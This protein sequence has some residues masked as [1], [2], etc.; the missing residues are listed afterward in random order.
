MNASVDSSAS[1]LIQHWRRKYSD[2]VHLQVGHVGLEQR[3]LGVVVEPFEPRHD[4]AAVGLE[5]DQPQLG[6]ALAHAAGEQERHR[7][8]HVEG[9][10]QRLAEVDVVDADAGCRPPRWIAMNAGACL[11]HLVEVHPDAR[12]RE[13]RVEERVQAERE[14]RCRTRPARSGRTRSG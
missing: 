7:A 14:G 11:V 5:E 6:V 1:K 10:R 3:H 8:H 12:A 13:A 9:I 4:P 2:G